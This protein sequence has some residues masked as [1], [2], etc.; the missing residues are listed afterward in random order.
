MIIPVAAAQSLLNTSSLFRILIESRTPQSMQRVID[1]AEN[2]IRE[3][4]H[5]EQDVTVITQDAVIATFDRILSALTYALAAIAAISLAVAG[6]LIMNVMLVAV[7]QRTAEIGLLKALGASRTQILTLILSEAVLLSML[8]ALFGFILGVGGSWAMST[9]IGDLEAYPPLWSM[10]AAML[11]AVTTGLLF[12]LLPARK[13]A[14]L[15][16]VQ[17]LQGHA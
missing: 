2:T 5:G 16:A 14:R 9:A 4:H 12:S 7:S 11:V 8:G 17:A 13:A 15:D 10:V 1:F 6:I 3:R